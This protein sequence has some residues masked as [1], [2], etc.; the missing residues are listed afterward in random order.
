MKIYSLS[1]KRPITVLM[2]FLGLLVLGVIAVYRLPVEFL[3]DVSGSRMW[4]SFPYRS[5][6]PED[7]ERD[8][9]TP[10][11]DALSTLPGLKSMWSR[12]SANSAGISLNFEGSDTDINILASEVRDRLDRI[13]D[14]FPSDF[15]RYYIWKHDTNALPIVWAG[16]PIGDDYDKAVFLQEVVQRELGSVIGVSRVELD[17]E[18][19]STILLKIDQNKLKALK[20]PFYLIS[21]ALSRNNIN[22]SLGTIK[23]RYEEYYVRTSNKLHSMDEIRNIIIKDNI[24]VKDVAKITHRALDD[25]NYST[26][27]GKRAIYF[28]VYKESGANTLKTSTA[29]KK[30]IKE[31]ER[32]Y[33]ISIQVIFMQ[34][35]AISDSL[36]NLLNNGIWGA[37][38]AIFVLIF[39]LRR[40][41]LTLIIAF[42]IPLS[43]IFTLG[44]MYFFNITLNIVS[45]MG[46][47][48]VVGMLVDNAV[49]VTESIYKLRQEGYGMV[50]A[51]LKGLREIMLA[52]ISASLT[53]IIVFLPLLFA[54]G[55]MGKYLKYVG[56]TIVI[57]LVI[58][59][60]SSIMLIPLF[61][62]VFMRNLKNSKDVTAP[63]KK[64]YKK[65]LNWTLSHRIYAV[66]FILVFLFSMIIPV[67]H[68][69]MRASM[70]QNSESIMIRFINAGGINK[71]TLFNYAKQFEDAV[72][73][74]K[75]KL[76]VKY[77]TQNVRPRGIKFEVYPTK[78]GIKF[79][80]E[81]I[82][83]QLKKLFPRNAV[84]VNI[85]FGWGHRSGGGTSN[86]KGVFDI[87]IYG[88]NYKELYKIAQDLEPMLYKIDGIED[89]DY[90]Q[91][92]TTKELEISLDK[93]KATSLG[94]ENWR[95]LS[96]I[97]NM[98][99]SKKVGYIENK[100]GDIDIY[101]E[102]N[103]IDEM[104]IQKLKATPIILDNGA[105]I[106]LSS[107]AKFKIAPAKKVIIHDNR[108]V[109]LNI[110]LTTN[111]ENLSALR[112]D[113]TSM[114]SNYN[115][116]KGYGLRMGE[117]FKEMND[118][119]KELGGQLL[120]AFLLVYMVM[121]SLFESFNMPVA[122]VVVLPVAFAGA[123]W[124]LYLTKAPFDIMAQ[125]G[126][127]VLIG[128]AVNNGIVI[129]DHINRLRISGLTRFD[130]IIKG[131]VDRLRPVFMTTF[132]TVLGIS[133]MAF[134]FQD[135]AYMKYS[136]MS[137]TVIFGLLT[138]MVI[139]L[140]LLPVVYTL[141]DDFSE[142]HVKKIR[143]A[144]TGR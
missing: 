114:V 91:D 25:E 120:L 119:M 98:L 136:S 70:R 92:S 123:F 143:K 57:A 9:L 68:I 71:E 89:V 18:I 24:K 101:I 117:D 46:L 128:V 19:S 116:P 28:A 75:K 133:P 22:Y 124:G 85:R 67:S 63:L 135:S 39:F 112:K 36:N 107:I 30:R 64:V 26:I 3:P 69:D 27:N 134:G 104:T 76:K 6:T 95:V 12:A 59:L 54:G 115:F 49:V 80:M 60:I 86:R 31:I 15:D 61:S 73:K 125:M 87:N 111:R 20:I 58:S 51:I 100:T 79:G 84:G 127:M 108:E 43:I 53:T 97:S 94:L 33:G 16:I 47:M 56:A 14:K 96:T 141:F 7:I 55:T 1:L 77:I 50:K 4:I 99:R 138:S 17:S 129:I 140:V 105:V 32:K 130:A 48:I 93:E 13:K 118:N 81:K 41:N 45:M 66:F 65:I 42:E 88:K 2:L 29:L 110:T 102:K 35:D 90:G 106:Q 78:D 137:I 44:V 23:G 144:F 34:S 131:G 74:N 40:L 121:A 10:A 8:I 142:F 126:L 83:V 11:E 113:I 37:I 109:T 139:T 122:I 132:T 52:V 5:S 103:D 72:L 38:F 82:K 21:S 62:F